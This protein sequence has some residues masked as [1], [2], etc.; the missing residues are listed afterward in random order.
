MRKLFFVCILISSMLVSS[1]V[2]ILAQASN[3]SW[4]QWVYELKLDAV[5]QGIRPAFF[6]RMFAGISP[7]KRVTHFSRTQ[8]E[9]RLTFREYRNTR[10]SKYRIL[11]GKRKF[12]KH[13]TILEKIGKEY[14]VSPCYIASI[15]G[16]ETSYGN[17][18][19]SFPV[20]R[21]L[22]TLAYSSKR[23]AYF[24][25]ELL[26]ALNIL[27]QGHVSVKDYKGEWAGASGHPQFMPSSWIKYAQDYNGDGKKDIWKTLPD[28]FAS[29]ANYLKQ[30]GWIAGEP[31]R[32]QVSA[33]Y[34]INRNLMG[35]KNE[36]PVSEWSQMGVRAENGSRLPSR[37]LQASLVEPYG[38]PYFLVFN[39][40]KVVMRYNNSIYYAGSIAYMADQ[41]CKVR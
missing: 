18:M 33:P 34:S 28:V 32:I 5:D 9:R 10:A 21:S 12:K 20:I 2:P 37:N 3:Q 1:F 14:G 40:F 38:G 22:A 4:R 29:I 15:W 13:R 17:F 6:D 30:K 23:K 11:I 36:L 19:G 35:L 31:V 7:N 24:R 8:P 39:N 25:S 16:M 41:I 27:Q 26:H